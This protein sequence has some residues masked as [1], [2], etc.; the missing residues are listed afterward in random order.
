MKQVK[1]VNVDA[2]NSYGGSI[3][4]KDG[5]VATVE[6]SN[7]VAKALAADTDIKSLKPGTLNYM[8]GKFGLQLVFTHPTN[9]TWCYP[10]L[11][12]DKRNKPVLSKDG[13]YD[14]FNVTL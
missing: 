12:R 2:V 6:V 1:S 5:L 10:G 4:N 7:T 9:G 3:W 8:Q 11:L 14:L 13:S